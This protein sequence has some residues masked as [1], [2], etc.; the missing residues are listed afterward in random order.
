MQEALGN[1]QEQFFQ[2]ESV[3]GSLCKQ[4]GQNPGPVGNKKQ[5]HMQCL[6]ALAIELKY[7]E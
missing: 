4:D 6:I 2:D 5:V 7:N 3:K 1:R